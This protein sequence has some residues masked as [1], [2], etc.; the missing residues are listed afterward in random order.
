MSV[1]DEFNLKESR[2]KELN[3]FKKMENSPHYREIGRRL[4]YIYPY[5]ASANVPTKLS[6]TELKN[7]ED[8]EFSKLRYKI[9]TLVDI[10]NYNENDDKFLL[11]KEISGAEI[12]TLLHFVLEHLDLKGDLKSYGIVNT[13]KRM[14]ERKLLTEDE[15]KIAAGT[16]AEKIEE[17][18]KTAIGKRMVNSDSVYREVP[19]VLRKKA[20][21]VLE[22]LNE[23]DLI[24]VQ[25][26]I[27]SYF[28]EDNE[29]VIVDYKTDRI[30]E[31]KNVAAQVQKLKEEY[32]DQVILYKEALEKIT[33]IKVKECYL[34]LFSIGKEVQIL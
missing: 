27:D 32:E 21:D 20:N 29:A 18:F 22:S 12:G 30:D 8:K 24:L 5:A 13:I 26:I 7:L 11:D 14:E 6:V 4:S 17:F 15:A 33:G 16:Y 23:E 25:G 19:F 1:N 2:I 3:E 28:I 34:Y 10:F 9:P 31:R